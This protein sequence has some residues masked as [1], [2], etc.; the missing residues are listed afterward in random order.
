MIHEF[1]FGRVSDTV[2]AMTV[3]RRSSRMGSMN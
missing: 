3:A 1:D 2:E